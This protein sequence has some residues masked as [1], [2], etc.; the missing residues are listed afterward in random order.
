[1]QI[2]GKYT[3]RARVCCIIILPYSVFEQQNYHF[4]LPSYLIS[5]HSLGVHVYTVCTTSQQSIQMERLCVRLVISYPVQFTLFS[6]KL[7]SQLQNECT[8]HINLSSPPDPWEG[9]I[10]TVA[11]PPGCPQSLPC[12]LPL[13]TL[14]CPQRVSEDCLFLNVFTPLT[15]QVCT[16]VYMCAGV[17]LQQ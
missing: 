15:A 7:T 14:L 12:K 13:P 5:L 11:D 8:T 6:C 3:D 4:K 16:C 9:V 1:M 2:Q 10:H 17:Q